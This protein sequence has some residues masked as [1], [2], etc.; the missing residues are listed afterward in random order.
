MAT[1]QRAVVVEEQSNRS[2]FG[3][4]LAVVLAGFSGFWLLNFSMGIFEI[5]DILPVVGN[6]DEAA[7]AWML[8]S[9]LSY[10]GFN[11]VPNANKA[12]RFEVK[13]PD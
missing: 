12:S 11:V 7:A 2:L 10:L 4:L 8:F 1:Q 5:P 6:I 13:K 9:S 3:K